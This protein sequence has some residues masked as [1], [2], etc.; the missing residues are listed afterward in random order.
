MIGSVYRTSAGREAVEAAY[1][2]FLRHWPVP[3]ERLRV[4][5]RLGETFVVA[6]G[7]VDG[8]PLVL[9]HGSGTNAAMWAGDVATWAERFRVYAVDL[10]GEPGHS[11][12]VRPPLGSD[13][14]AGWL[15][16]VLDGLGAGSVALVGASL[17]G[18]LAT[19][20]AARRPARVTRLVLLCPG[21]I[22]RQKY[23]WLLPALL[24]RPF[25]E[26][27]MRRQLAL[28]AGV[29]GAAMRPVADYMSLIFRHF[30]P[31]TERLPIFPDATLATLTVPVLVIAGE[32]DAMLDSRE[33][34]RRVAAAVP[35]AET[36]L[37][38]GVA[39]AV[40]GQASRI[41]VFLTA[42]R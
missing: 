38:P 26:W 5:T 39:H 1:D 19:D 29:R 30:K 31:R 13:E 14:H 3:M 15:D 18:W 4:P 36:V 41:H 6:S 17:G 37:L 7:P 11:A 12:A 40:L 25:G 22:G 42:G 20:Y 10:P 35:H 2:E 32:R 21:G 28:V 8:P 23:G 9:L 24:L 27:G 33:T 34:L 16:D